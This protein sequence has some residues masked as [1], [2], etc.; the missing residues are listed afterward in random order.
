MGL[1]LD[2][3]ATYWGIEATTAGLPF[4]TYR[5]AA[6]RQN[7]RAQLSARYRR[8]V[9]LGGRV[10]TQ[11]WRA[12]PEPEKSQRDRRRAE[13]RASLRPV[14]QRALERRLKI[15]KA[16]DKRRLAAA[17]SEHR[18]GHWK[19]QDDDPY[20]LALR[21]VFAQYAVVESAAWHGG[22]GAGSST[23]EPRSR[24]APP[25]SP[26]SASAS[27]RSRVPPHTAR[28]P[29]GAAGRTGPSV[30]D[31]ADGHRR[32]HRRH[33]EARLP[34]LLELLAR[35]LQRGV[36]LR[37]GAPEATSG[38]GATAGR[39]RL[40]GDILEKATT[41]ADSAYIGQ[42][43]DW[44]LSEDPDLKGLR[45][46]AEFQRFEVMFLPGGGD[47]APAAERAPSSRARAT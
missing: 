21:G 27:A 2:A 20:F 43:R 38:E 36:R 45:A 8:L 15:I 13:L 10:L 46:T 6:R 14:L 29:R 33:R 47:S 18:L 34:R 16:R 42:R 39:R 22:C 5:G 9:L 19:E 12:A 32:P 28:G 30:A 4:F 7:R 44:L 40:Q 1:F 23:G 37:A 24:R 25:W 3:L 17:L 41:R 35:A 11:Q 31:A 26:R